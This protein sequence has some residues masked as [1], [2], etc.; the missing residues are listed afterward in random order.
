[1]RRFALLSFAAVVAAAPPARG[2]IC[3]PGAQVACACAAG[4]QGVQVCADDGARLGACQCAAPPPPAAP[5]PAPP[6]ASP[7]PPPAGTFYAPP[8]APGAAAAPPSYQAPPPVGASAN[9]DLPFTPLR[10]VFVDGTVRG[11]F[12][13]GSSSALH[14]YRGGVEGGAVLHVALAP[15]LPG[16]DGGNW[17]GLAARFL[18][19]VGGAGIVWSAHG[20]IPTDGAAQIVVSGVAELGYEIAHFRKLGLGRDK[21]GGIGGFIGFRGGLDYT[22]IVWTTSRGGV[23]PTVGLAASLVFPEHS[24]ESRRF[25]AGLVNFGVWTA[26]GTGITFL[27][28]GGGAEF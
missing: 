2:G 1:M 27:T 24:V 4:S 5:A 26:P 8:S 12:V 17:H 14:I 21:H 20:N 11:G 15:T 9:R 10:R 25:G 16:E 18:A 3:V 7:P 19:G 28:I 13:L 22:E 6:G 23:D